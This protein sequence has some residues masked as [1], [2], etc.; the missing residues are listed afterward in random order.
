VIQREQHRL[1]AW[2]RIVYPLLASALVFPSDRLGGNRLLVET[3][4][5][6]L[7][8]VFR[9][10][11]VVEAMAHWSL[12][13]ATIKIIEW[14]TG[15]TEEVLTLV[16]RLRQKVTLSL[17]P[18][19]GLQLAADGEQ[20]EIPADAGIDRLR[21]WLE[22]IQFELIH[23]RTSVPDPVVE[24]PSTKL[25]Q[26]VEVPAILE[27]FKG[28]CNLEE[29]PTKARVLAAARTTYVVWRQ[30]RDHLGYPAL[31]N[32]PLLG[33]REDGAGRTASSSVTPTERVPSERRGASAKRRMLD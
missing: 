10:P 6:Y 12:P 16:R 1:T 30:T 9:R 5:R 27:Y 23:H 14:T 33:P 29:A 17:S 15:Q 31:E 25:L 4:R 28:A 22:S 13:L 21:V 3:V 20:Q 19:L 8:H 32:S 26:L 11:T 18:H 7:F 2:E 24:P